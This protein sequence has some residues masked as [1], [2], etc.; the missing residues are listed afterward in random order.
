[1]FTVHGWG[2]Y[3]T[4]FSWFAPLVRNGEKVMAEI[5]DEIVCVSKNDLSQ[6]QKHN[7]TQRTNARVIH[8]GIPPLE[9]D[10][11]RVRIADLCDIDSESVVLG[12][13]SRL[14]RQK[15]PLELLRV[16]SHLEEIGL[17]VEVVH[18]GNGPLKS[19]CE[20]YI[21]RKGIENVHMLGFV[22]DALDL[23]PD[24][25]VFL[26]PSAFEGFPLTVLESMHTGTP[27]V[28]YDVGGV[29]EAIQDGETGYVVLQDDYTQ[30]L[31]RVIDL[32]ENDERRTEMGATAKSVA[33]ERFTADRMV[34]EYE[35]VYIKTIAEAQAGDYYD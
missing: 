32:I 22:E 25:D 14:A 29:A 34:G 2:F 6:G 9:F 19:E 17:D 20:N 30:F 10:D 18:I 3:N 33:Q 4:E 8:N 26:L 31:D 15:N 23:L 7:I 24:I 11:D 5:T 28:G 27:T 21:R 13:I 12:S 1:M 16:A 35:D